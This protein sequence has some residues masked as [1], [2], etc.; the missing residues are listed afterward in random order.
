[1]SDPR[2]SGEG[3]VVRPGAISALLETLYRA[4]S[5]RGAGAAEPFHPGQV[6]GRFELVRE[7]GRGGFGV[8]YEARD[9][10]LRRAV[11][12]KAVR[13]GGALDARQQR[14]LYEAEAAARLAHPN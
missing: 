1:M 2:D 7:L 14:L 8:V 9:R 11:A 4:P 12:F 6:V 5:A 13:V 10:E 3:S